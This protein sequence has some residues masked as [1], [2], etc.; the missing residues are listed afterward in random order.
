ME[1]VIKDIA[2]MQRTAE[3]LRNQGRRI[4]VV[5]TMGCLHQGHLK[6]LEV[7][8]KHADVVITSI[9]VNPT[10]FGPTEDFTR[11][12]RDLGRDTQLA[13]AAGTDYVFAPETE[14]MYPPGYH[15]YIEVERLTEMLEGKSR[16]GHFRG[17]TTVVGKIFSITKPAVAV[18]GQ[19][20]AQQVAVVRQ[21]IRDMNFDIE[22]VVCPIVREPDGLAMSSRNVYLSKEQRSQAPVLYM[23]IARAEDLIRSGE[24]SCEKVI[25]R[26]KTLIATNSS[27]VVD[28]I[29]IAD[30]TTLEELNECRG[31]LLISLAVRFGTTRL[32]DNATITI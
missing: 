26:M 21:M 32:I 8:R 15:T 14:S 9:F 23:S 24:R 17:V 30:S 11:Y 18:F 6:L 25:D 20:D 10:Q 31:S 29:S 7:A 28:Y 13:S 19:K 27:G 4:G 3:R 5:P 22:L 1:A 2:E 16:P 12:P